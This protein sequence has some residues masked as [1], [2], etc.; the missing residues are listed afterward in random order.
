M[1]HKTRLKVVCLLIATVV[2][3][4]VRPPMRVYLQGSEPRFSF[5]G[6]RRFAI[7]SYFDHTHPDVNYNTID[8]EVAAYTTERGLRSNNC[9][10]CY[11]SGSVQVCGYYTVLQDAANCRAAGGR[12]IYYDMHPA[13]DYGFP[14]YTAIAAA[15]SG[16]ALQR[17][18]LG[19]AVVIDH[20]GN[21]FSRYGHVD[22]T[23][24]IAH[25]TPVVRGQQVALSSNTGTG[26]AH[27]HFEA[28]FN[29]EYGTVFDPYGWWGPWYTDP[30]NQPWGHTEPWWRS[31]DPIPM[32][33]RDQNHAPQ[34]PYQLTGV[35]EGKWYDLIGPSSPVSA[36]ASGSCPGN[37]GDCQFFE[38]GYMRWDY[39]SVTYYP[40]AE[41]L[42]GRVHY[43]AARNANTILSIQNLG[44]APAQV[45]V[46]F[47][48]NG[49]VI[50]SRTYRTL[51]SYATWQLS[52]QLALQDLT[53]HFMGTAAIYSNQ[54]VAYSINYV[55]PLP[56]V[57]LPLAIK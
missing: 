22:R 24:R 39:S 7:T 16:T 33:Y 9:F 46:I 53:N 5:P 49:R 15:E 6:A 52:T 51:T 18:I 30:W 14:M 1:K 50:D 31:G 11:P 21:Y 38:K 45:S 57:F 27:L 28:R 19:Y 55:N 13:F 41:S 10:D 36:Q 43:V 47:L 25:N 4:V 3:N 34:G 56:T 42:V 54:P 44:G 32:G 48:E 37:Y 29:G 2:I 12:R 26:A 40:Y 23:S 17:D 35:M 8:N 20:G